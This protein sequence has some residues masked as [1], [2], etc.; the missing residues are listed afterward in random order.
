MGNLHAEPSAPHALPS[1][2]VVEV[3]GKEQMF[4]LRNEELN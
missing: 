1:V 3:K 2:Y 4:V